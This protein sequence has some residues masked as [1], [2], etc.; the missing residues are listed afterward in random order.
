[1]A[2]EIEESV[3]FRADAWLDVQREC[4]I[5]HVVGVLH[6]RIDDRDADAIVARHEL[7][8]VEHEL[9]DACTLHNSQRELSETSVGASEMRA[10]LVAEVEL[11]HGIIDLRVG[12]I[13][14]TNREWATG[15]G[16]GAQGTMFVEKF[17]GVD[18]DFARTATVGTTVRSLRF[19]RLFKAIG[20]VLV[21]FS[22]I[23]PHD[24]CRRTHR[25]APRLATTAMSKCPSSPTPMAKSP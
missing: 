9:D 15:L 5:H 13:T 22:E 4:L 14:H 19:M 3:A 1:M 7:Q 8:C 23:L 11:D 16:R 10:G 21:D 12:G 6:V 18:P 2:A 24:I 25:L 20:F 17:D